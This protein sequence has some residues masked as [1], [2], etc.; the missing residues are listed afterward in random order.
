MKTINELL[1]IRKLHRD[2][3]IDD[4]T[5]NALKDWFLERNDPRSTKLIHCQVWREEYAG[6]GNSEVWSE[7]SPYGEDWF[8]SEHNARCA[9][10]AQIM[11]FL[12]SGEN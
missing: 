11:N 10:A 8:S 5:L 2:Q 4:Y 7:I 9:L 6:Y 12:I 1:W 3:T